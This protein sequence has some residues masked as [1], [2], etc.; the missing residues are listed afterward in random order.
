MLKTKFFFPYTYARWTSRYKQ[1]K[2]F[3][4]KYHEKIKPSSFAYFSVGVVWFI[5]PYGENKI[6]MDFQESSSSTH[7]GNS[8]NIQIEARSYEG[9]KSINLT[10][11]NT[12]STAQQIDIPKGTYFANTVGRRQ[13][14][15]AQEDITIHLLPKQTKSI[16]IKTFCAHAGKGLPF[17]DEMEITNLIYSNMLLNK[18]K[19]QEEKQGELWNNL[20]TSRRNAT[21]KRKLR[22]EE[23]KLKLE[24]EETKNKVAQ[25]KEAIKKSQN[26]LFSEFNKE[27][28]A[29]HSR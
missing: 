10:L 27:S 13:P 2:I 8:Q 5:W 29:I 18:N 26:E 17:N 23:A 16:R 7:I 3:Y 19:N 28:A 22:L 14:L 21:Q 6:D 24:E 9:S 4:H 1:K 25:N 12:S 15:I 11:V 20:D